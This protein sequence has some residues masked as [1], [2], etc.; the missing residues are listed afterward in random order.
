MVGVEV[1]KGRLAQ[2]AKQSTSVTI[3]ASDGH[4][5]ITGTNK[6]W[7]NVINTESRRVIHSTHLC[8]SIII[9]LRLTPDGSCLVSNSS[10]RIVRTVLLPDLSQLDCNQEQT[11]LSVEHRFQDVVNRLAWNHVTFSSSGDYVTATTYENHD[12][13]VW[14]RSQGSL[15]KILEGPKEEL[16]VV[17]VTHLNYLFPIGADHCSGIPINHTLRLVVLKPVLFIFGSSSLGSA[18]LP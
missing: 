16:G 12:V 13:Y 18:G 3:F 8:S 1:N 2:N 4:H 7:I 10:D 15:V 14:E 17:E 6:G 5:I 11:Q 9:L